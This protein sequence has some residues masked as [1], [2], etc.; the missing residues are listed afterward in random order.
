MKKVLLSLIALASLCVAVQAQETDSLSTYVVNSK[1]PNSWFVG[2]GGGVNVLYDG[3]QYTTRTLSH[4]GAGIA[5]DVYAGKWLDRN[6]GLRVGYH[7]IN[8]SNQKTVFGK[9]P[10]LYAHGDVMLRPVSWIVPYFH[11]GY[12]RMEK[13]SIGGGVGLM[14]PIH[15]GRVSIVPDFRATMADGAA[16]NKD[17]AKRFGLNLSATVGLAIRFGGKQKVET[18]YVD[19]NVYVP[20]EKVDTVVVKQIDTV[21]IREVIKGKADEL[22]RIMSGL[23]LFDI[24]SS[25]LRPEAFPVL[26]D[27]ALFLKENPD[28]KVTVEGHADST[29]SD[30]INQP[31]SERRARAVAEYLIQ[32][33]VEMNRVRSIGYGSTR[34]KTTNDTP[35]G[36]QLNRRMEFVFDIK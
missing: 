22:N 12:F 3:E 23:V 19:R 32:R 26:N 15:V 36:R 6:V 34:P 30:R 35:L 13:A 1:Y 5:L 27:A 21:Y 25:V 11:A 10:F 2:V 24:N 16:V 8:A 7:G 9:S 29:G 33:G 14:L 28:V 4:V 31:L 18:R 17:L 20:V